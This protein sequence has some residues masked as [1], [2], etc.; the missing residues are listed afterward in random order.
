M[1]PRPKVASAKSNEPAST[2]T[3]NASAEAKDKSDAKSE[4]KAAD[5]ED[6]DKKDGTSETK[7][8]VARAMPVPAPA[9]TPR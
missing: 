2:S 4:D 6:K 1:K 5:K 8:P 9:E 3:K 7:R